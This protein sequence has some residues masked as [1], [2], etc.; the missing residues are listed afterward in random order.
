LSPGSFLAAA[1]GVV[2]PAIMVR[3]EEE[4]AKMNRFYLLPG[5]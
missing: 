4:E 5:R 2:S 1:E 3:E